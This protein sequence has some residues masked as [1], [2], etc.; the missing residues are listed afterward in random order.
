MTLDVRIVDDAQ[1]F[2][3]SME[4]PHPPAVGD[5]IEIH[6]R[7]YKITRVTWV[8]TRPFPY[9]TPTTGEKDEHSQAVP[10]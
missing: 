10:A 3:H 8:T 4:L 5:Y 2:L 7:E 6:S 9:M 1:K